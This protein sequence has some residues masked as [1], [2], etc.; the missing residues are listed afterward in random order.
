MDHRSK[1]K[2]KTSRK[3]HRRLWV[4][5]RVLRYNKKKYDPKKEKN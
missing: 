1:C 5:L 2:T 3:E 4:N